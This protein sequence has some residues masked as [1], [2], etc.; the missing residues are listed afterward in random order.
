[1]LLVDHRQLVER[2][3]GR[4]RGERIVLLVLRF[5]RNGH[6]TADVQLESGGAH[7]EGRQRAAIRVTR[8]RNAEVAAEKQLGQRAVG[9]NQARTDMCVRK[10]IER[11]RETDSR[12]VG[13]V[14]DVLYVR[15]NSHG[16]A[17]S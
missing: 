1:M 12:A 3:L 8:T 11:D 2:L 4:L 16:A 14:G 10:K 15:G 6:A 7:G 9:R 17:L 5:L 13:S